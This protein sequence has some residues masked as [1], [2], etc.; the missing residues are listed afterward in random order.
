MKDR[1]ILMKINKEKNYD[2][3]V[4]VC[5]AG[6][7]NAVGFDE[8]PV[9]ENVAYKNL[10]KSRIKQLGFYGSNNLEIIDLGY[11]AQAMQDMRAHNR[12]GTVTPGTKGIQLP[13]ANV[14]LDYI[15]DDYGVLVISISFGGTGFTGD[16]PFGTYSDVLKKPIELGAGEGT[17]AQK[18]GADTAYYQTLRDRIKYALELNEENRFA[19]II[20]CQGENDMLDANMHKSCFEAMT[21]KLFKE[22]NATGLGSRT[23]KGVWDRDVW[24]N[25]ETVGYW[26]GQGQC[27]QIWD[28][29][30]AWNKKTYV[31]IPRDTESNEVNGT[32]QTASVRGAHFGNNAYEKVVAP[33]VLKKM[34]EM[35]AFG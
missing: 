24:Y 9:D 3:F 2:K 25:M 13:L 19:G 18:W 16:A 12:A 17:T 15:P 21:S 34:M 27:Q 20:W 23:P 22:L 33:R 5:I 28:N 31:E 35:N 8:S 10:D 11:C 30:K 29:Y 1:G 4:V 6:Q 26:Y 7:S 32:G 14:M